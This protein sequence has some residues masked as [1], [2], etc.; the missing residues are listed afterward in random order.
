VTSYSTMP[1]DQ[2]IDDETLPEDVLRD[3]L[4][5]GREVEL[6]ELL[7]LI[8]PAGA[9]TGPVAV[10]TAELVEPSSESLGVKQSSPS[11]ASVGLDP[12][13]VGLAAAA[14]P[15][16]VGLAGSS[17]ST[18]GTAAGAW[19]GGEEEDVISKPRVVAVSGPAGVGKSALARKVCECRRGRLY[20]DDA[21]VCLHTGQRFC[22]WPAPVTAG[23]HRLK[24]LSVTCPPCRTPIV[25]CAQLCRSIGL[26]C[27][28]GKSASFRTV[29]WVDC[30]SEATASRGLSRACESVGK[31]ITA[32]GVEESELVET[33]KKLPWFQPTMHCRRLG[34]GWEGFPLCEPSP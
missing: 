15:E 34:G 12:H 6:E 11:A 3:E 29:L 26:R 28:D 33:V 21:H 18:Q 23:A 17:P 27:N 8:A 20:G 13:G 24:S 16:W 30:V 31:P 5:L 2:L 22:C 4:F 10:A 1:A 14:G 9:A 19:A 25:M 32:D 7:K